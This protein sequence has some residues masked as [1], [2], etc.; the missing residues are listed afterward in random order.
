M[1]FLIFSIVINANE[2]NPFTGGTSTSMGVG[3]QGRYFDYIIGGSSFIDKRDTLYI[4]GINEKI[5]YN[6]TIYIGFGGGIYRNFYNTSGIKLR[7]SLSGD[8]GIRVKKISNCAS[9]ILGFRI[10]KIFPS[11]KILPGIFLSGVLE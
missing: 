11:D 6:R 1:V 2:F 9:I 5:I 10:L 4:L 8:I 7:I 3:M